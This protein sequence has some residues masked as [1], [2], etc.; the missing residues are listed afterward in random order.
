M[1]TVN[2]YEAKTHLSRLIEQVEAGEEIVI[3]RSGRPVA[4]LV[5]LSQERRPIR[6]GLMRGRLTVPADFD[7]PLPEEVLAAF[8]GG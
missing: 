6:F 5:P 1:R 2:I 7:A 3:A 4:R 8:E